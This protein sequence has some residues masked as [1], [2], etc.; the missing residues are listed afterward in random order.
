M[1][2]EEIFLGIWGRP[3]DTQQNTALD[4]VHQVGTADLQGGQSPRAINKAA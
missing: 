1:F 4:L 3:I 2:G